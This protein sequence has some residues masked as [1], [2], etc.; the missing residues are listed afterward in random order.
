M[1]IRTP[2][3]L[4]AISRQHVHPRPSPQVTVP[5]RAPGCALVRPGCGTSVLYPP[6]AAASGTADDQHRP[7]P[8]QPHGKAIARP[9]AR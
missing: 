6:R 9:Y 5:T 2:D 7:E 1:G 4:H 8:M 3:L